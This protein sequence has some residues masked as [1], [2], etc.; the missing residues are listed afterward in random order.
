MDSQVSEKET[1][2]VVVKTPN[3]VHGDQTI[4]NVNI[5]WTV[6]ELKTHL[7][8][9]YPS[10]P[11]SYYFMVVLIPGVPSQRKLAGFVIISELIPALCIS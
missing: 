10:K 7:A 8:R 1:I 4:E 9:I 2:S 3:Q 11:V 5:N 6:Q